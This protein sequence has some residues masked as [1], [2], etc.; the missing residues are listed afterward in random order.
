M[1]ATTQCNHERLQPLMTMDKFKVFLRSVTGGDLTQPEGF[2]NC[3]VVKLSCVHCGAQSY[4]IG[5]S[6]WHLERKYNYAPI[7]NSDHPHPDEQLIYFALIAQVKRKYADRLQKY[8][9]SK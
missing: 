3:E 6:H 9:L 1:K 2:Y 7:I 4:E 8:G 5:L